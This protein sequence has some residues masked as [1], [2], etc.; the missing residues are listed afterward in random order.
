LD[1]GHSSSSGEEARANEIVHGL[2]TGERP[3][4]EVEFD[5]VRRED[6]EQDVR[7]KRFYAYF[8]PSVMIGQLAVADAGFILYAWLGAKWDVAPSIM[9][10]WLGSTVVEVIAIVLVVTRYLFPRRDQGP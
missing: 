5:R 2:R 9:H 6:A 10:V 1:D 4:T 3:R 8:L 7:L